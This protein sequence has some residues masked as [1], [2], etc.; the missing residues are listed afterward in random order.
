MS[1]LNR[2]G[3]MVSAAVLAIAL[4]V[5]PNG[6]GMADISLKT[7][8][9]GDIMYCSYPTQLGLGCTACKYVRDCM[10]MVNGMPTMVSTY[11]TCTNRNV[12]TLCFVYQ[13]PA[14]PTPTCD[15]G[16][17]SVSC[18]YYTLYS[19]V[20]DCS[21]N[22]DSSIGMCGSGMSYQCSA[23]YDLSTSGPMASGVNC[24]NAA[25]GVY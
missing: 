12:S 17:R 8:R 7:I 24:Q 18:G 4:I 6:I 21:T 2:I 25:G 22:S 23:T 15:R 1:R 20:N 3:L 19:Y 11:S 5:P 9:G 14:D 10:E 13:T 16:V